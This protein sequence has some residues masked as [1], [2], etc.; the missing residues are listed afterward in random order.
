[1]RY[2]LF[3]LLLGLLTLTT[4][5]ISLASFNR[6]AHPPS[7]AARANLFQIEDEEYAVYSAL[8]NDD[9]KEDEGEP[10]RPKDR[11]L[12]IDESTSLW[13][14]MIE[15]EKDKF[16]E[17]LKKSSPELQAETVEDLQAKSTSPSTLARNFSIG[18]NYLLVSN[19]EIKEMF[20]G[21]GV[22]RGWEAFHRKY[23]NSGGI[24]T[25]SRVGFNADKTQA[26]VYKGWSCGGLCGGGGYTL[27]VK[28]KGAWVIKGHPG[29]SWVS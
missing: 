29:P 20:K 23:P 27:L 15:E 8:I 21:D 24:L 4:G 11:V 9:L 6:K 28:K 13:D 25:L 19:E 7:P 26:L 5:A 22:L 3:L 14:G 17:E 18:I 2:R 12:I 10:K 16:F 1:M